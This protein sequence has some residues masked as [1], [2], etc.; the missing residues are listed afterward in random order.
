MVYDRDALAQVQKIRALHLLGAVSVHNGKER[1]RIDLGGRFLRGKEYVLILRFA[2]Y[3]IYKRGRGAVLRIRNYGG[4]YAELP[5]KAAY[6][7][8]RA[9][10][11]QIAE[12]VTHD[13]HLGGVLYKLGEGVCHNAGLDL[14]ALFYLEAAAAVELEAHLILDNGLVAAAGKRKL[15]CHVRKLERLA[16]GVRIR[17]KANAYGRGNAARAFDLVHLLGDLELAGL[18]PLKVPPLHQDNVPVAV[19]AAQD[20]VKGRAPLAELVLHRVAYIVLYTLRLVLCK[21]LKV[22]DDDDSR[23]RAA[24]LILD[25]DVVIVR[26]VHPVGYAHERAF[27]LILIG[28]DDVAVQLIFPA[29]YLKQ[30]RVPG[31]A[32]EQPLARKLRHKLRQVRVEPRTGLA[33]H[34]EEH[35]VAP[36]NARIVQPEHRD[37]QRKIRQRAALG[38]LRLVGHGFDIRPELFLSSAL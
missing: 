16:E 36:D 21:L 27:L 38:V 2:A 7:D 31:L 9:D 19:I 11:V 25:A 26:D 20:A 5:R 32:L 23:D 30:C 37:R 29:A 33:A 35:F 18:E 17:A 6:A 15:P 13:E 8:R 22:I 34:F 28:A 4:V 12:A 1:V 24:V 3:H 10:A 14:G